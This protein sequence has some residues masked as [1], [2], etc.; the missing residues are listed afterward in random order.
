MLTTSK[1]VINMK[2]QEE[3]YNKL[4]KPITTWMADNAIKFLRIS[5]GIIFFW[6]GFLKF[7]PGVSSAEGLAT[8]TISVM[9]FELLQP[10]VSII[11][12]AAWETLIGL[13]LLFNK[14]IRE[15]LFLLFLQMIGTM[16]PLFFFPAETFKMF[17]FVP[18]LEGQYIIKNLILISAGLAIGATVRGGKIVPNTN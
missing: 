13:G 9:T 8:K 14:F 17:P 3:F 11:I 5:L 12:L 10:S 2:F 16:S 1:K 4:D 18:T 15:I 6:F 7:F